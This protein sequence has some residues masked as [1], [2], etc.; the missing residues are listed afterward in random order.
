MHDSPPPVCPAPAPTISF[1]IERRS[2]HDF[3]WSSR[4]VM[5]CRV[6]LAAGFMLI[7]FPPKVIPKRLRQ[8]RCRVRLRH[9]HVMLKTILAHM[10]HE[11]LELGYI[12]HRAI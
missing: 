8:N 4:S 9:D 12:G 6:L 1:S 5:S 11:F 7:N 3:N 10:L 2:A